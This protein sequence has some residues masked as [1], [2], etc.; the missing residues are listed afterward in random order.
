MVHGLNETNKKVMQIFYDL[1][2]NDFIYFLNH[3]KKWIVDGDKNKLNIET[4]IIRQINKRKSINSS[5]LSFMKHLS[6]PT[7]FLHLA[8]SPNLT[9]STEIENYE[10]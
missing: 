1:V 2:N 4:R 7:P 10:V 5:H 6:S 8:G 9:Y 3:Q